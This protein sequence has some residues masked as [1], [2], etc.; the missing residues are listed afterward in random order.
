NMNALRVVGKA[1]RDY[2]GWNPE[3]IQ[4]EIGRILGKAVAKEFRANRFDELLTELAGVWQTYKMGEIIPDKLEPLQFEAGDCFD[5]PGAP[6]IQ[7]NICPFKAGVL[8]AIF[9]EKLGAGT[10]VEEINCCANK[11]P[12]CRFNVIPLKA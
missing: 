1:L 8:T 3:P 7:K 10:K 5:C 6:D 12:K 2:Y 9:E 11:G 4:Y